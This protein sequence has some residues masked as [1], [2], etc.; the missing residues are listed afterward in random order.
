MSQAPDADWMLDHIELLCKDDTTTGREDQGLPALR[1]L[2]E[3]LGA[4]VELQQVE[5]GRHNIFA[6]WCEK[7]R[8][9][10]SSHVDTVPPFI[11]PRRSG[12]LLHGRGTC[13]AKGQVVSQLEAIRVLLGAGHTDL[14]WLGVVGEETNSIGAIHAQHFAPRCE[15]LK[16]VICGEPTENRLATGQR[17]T[18][19]VQI[20]VQGVPC[21]SGS[22]ELGQSAMWPLLD[23]LQ[24]LRAEGAAED[25]DLGTEIWN[26]GLIRG[27]EAPN[28]LA[29]KASADLLVRTLQDSNFLDRV[30]ELAPANSEVEVLGN[31]PP[32]RFP[33]LPGYHHSI[34]PFGSDAPRLRDLVPDRSVTLMGPGSISVAH[35]ADEHITKDDLESG[36]EL[37]V[38]LA[39]QTLET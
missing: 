7:P 16:T 32:D 19:H 8:L 5:P 21:H 18:M 35:T 33:E 27:G 17:G 15:N 4:E 14:A 25:P 6:S 10:L 29:A 2:L 1:D 3:Q 36:T 31:T 28:I 9:L 30:R 34:V 13:D 37:L 12:D 24:K 20:R 26:L 11:A 23:W 22:P 38:G 39:N